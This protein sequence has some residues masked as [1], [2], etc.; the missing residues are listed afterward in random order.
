MANRSFEIFTKV[1]DYE[2]NKNVAYGEK[3]GYII[4]LYQMRFVKAFLIPLP[5]ITD[6]QKKQ[7]ISYLKSQ[8]AKFH[9]KRIY[10]DNTV[11]VIK[12]IENFRNVD[13]EILNNLIDATINFLQENK[14][15]YGKH[16]IFCGKDNADDK[17]KIMNIEYYIHRKCYDNALIE[18][19]KEIKKTDDKKNEKPN[20]NEEFA[21]PL[22]LASVFTVGLLWFL[23][24][25]YIWFTGI[26]MLSCGK[27]SIRI[28]QSFKEKIPNFH[29]I[30]IILG[31]IITYIIFSYFILVKNDIAIT[32]IFEAKHE[33]TTLN[34]VVAL[35]AF[36]IGL[37]FS[38][39]RYNRDE[40]LRK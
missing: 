19:E 13:V 35:N 21:L 40:R 30:I 39:S 36:I 29:K 37:L 20:K 10:F 33:K 12:I 38:F 23:I 7:V 5:S 15:A 31:I 1:N 26:L 9:I 2:V 28:Y 14:I 11:L 34:L 18:V 4:T 3:N 8:K 22:A 24:S 27:F 6:L 25:D 32:Q 17:T 16:C